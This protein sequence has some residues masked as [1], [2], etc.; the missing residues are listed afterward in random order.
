MKILVLNFW[1]ESSYRIISIYAEDEDNADR[2][3]STE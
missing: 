1:H 2:S 3:K